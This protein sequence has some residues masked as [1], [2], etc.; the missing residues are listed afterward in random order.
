MGIN[1]NFKAELV[2]SF[3]HLFRS[4]QRHQNYATFHLEKPGRADQG[5]A[6]HRQ[7]V[8]PGSTKT[9]GVVKFLQEV[10]PRLSPQDA[11]QKFMH[12]IAPLR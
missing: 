6:S 9:E 5:D 7:C 2:G 12:E 8:L 3:G 4:L 11:E 10:F 1:R